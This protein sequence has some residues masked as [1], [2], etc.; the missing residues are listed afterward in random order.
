MVSSNERWMDMAST[1]AGQSIMNQYLDALKPPGSLGLYLL[2]WL[3]Q[4]DSGLRVDTK[5]LLMEIQTN[6][7][8]LQSA[9]I[10]DS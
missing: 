10:V 7:G 5:L 6:K 3:P 9:M 1:C 8:H 4:M 2:V